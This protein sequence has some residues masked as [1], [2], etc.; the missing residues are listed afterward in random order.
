M[1]SDGTITEVA[2]QHERLAEL[3][4]R[5]RQLED[6]LG[7]KTDNP[8]IERHRDYLEERWSQELAETVEDL[9]LLEEL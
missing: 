7:R 2:L 1:L 4:A 6:Q 9:F 5:Q 8:I 3:L